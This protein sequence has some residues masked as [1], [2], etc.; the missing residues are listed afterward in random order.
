MLKPQ[1][2][3][4]LL[5][6]AGEP[7]DWTFKNLAKELGLS[8]SEVHGALDRA[9]ESGLYDPRKRKVK[10]HA[11]LEF[12]EHGIPY[13]F[14]AKRLPRCQGIPTAYSAEPLKAKFVVADD[15]RVVWPHSEGTEYGDA[16]EPLYRSAPHAAF[17][18]PKLHRRLALI[19]ALRIGR[20]RERKMA[21]EALD[22]EL[23]A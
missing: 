22:K 10:E 1:D 3:L 14:P 7:T 11:L 4:V 6:L 23:R 21:A 17:R 12:A 5:R 20:A 15:D 16:I 18:N 8:A 2:V 9:T 19:D 13:V